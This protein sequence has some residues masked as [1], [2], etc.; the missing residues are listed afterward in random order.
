MTHL[1]QT[2]W[3][4]RAAA[5]TS[6]LALCT[7]AAFAQTLA[8]D[9]A[10]VRATVP[11]QTGTGGF[12]RIT[13]KE[14]AK[15]VGIKSPVAAVGEVHEMKMEGSTMKM[16]ALKNGL[17][18]PAGEA[19]ELKPGGLHLMLLDLKATLAPG[20]NV[21]VT[22]QLQD[23]KGKR[24]ERTVNVAVSVRAPVAPGAASGASSAASQAGHSG[25][26]KD[27]AHGKHMH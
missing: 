18:L 2:T 22:L 25:V 8:V 19:V 10:W 7:G 15:L 6:A 12:M 24:F 17:N 27:H 26:T 5:V 3:T 20:T 11:G 13:S 4:A 21:P 14:G 23:A 1:T 9:G 16:A